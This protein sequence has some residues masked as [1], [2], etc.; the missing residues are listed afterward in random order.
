MKKLLLLV[1]LLTVS[2]GAGSQ[3]VRRTETIVA[4]LLARMPVYN[5]KELERQMEQMTLMESIGREIIL[6]SLTAPGMGD[7]TNARFAVESYSRYLSTPERSSQNSIW[8]LECIDFFNRTNIDEIKQFM[9]NQLIYSGGKPSALLAVENLEKGVLCESSAALLMS[10]GT[11]GIEKQVISLLDNDNLP[12]AAGVMNILAG[13]SSDRALDKLKK[14]YKNGTREEKRVALV[15][16]SKATDTEALSFLKNCA[17]K[18]GFISDYTGETDA[19]IAYAVNAGER[20]DTDV[21]AQVAVL[22]LKKGRTPVPAHYR[23]AALSMLAEF[24]GAEALNQIIQEFR[25]EDQRVSKSAIDFAGEIPG[26]SVTLK[27]CSLIKV[28]PADIATD[29]VAM[30]GHRGD[31]AASESL[32][33]ILFSS[34]FGVRIAGVGAIARLEGKESVETLIDYMRSFPSFEDQMAAMEALLFVADS[35][36]RKKIAEAIHDS[37]PVTKANLISLVAS[38]GESVYFPMV[39]GYCNSADNTIREI[40]YFSLPLVAR[41]GEMNLLISLALQNNNKKELEHLKIA[42]AQT[43]KYSEN[44]AAASRQFSESV[45]KSGYNINIL[46]VLPLIGDAAAVECLSNAFEAGDAESREFIYS[47]MKQ[48]PN[49]DIVHTLYELIASGNKSYQQRAFM[50]YCMR[51][52]KGNIPY[53]QKLLL[54]RRIEP[55]ATSPERKLALIGVAG[56]IRSFTNLMWLSGYIDDNDD[57]AKEAAKK[58]IAVALSGEEGGKGFGGDLAREIVKKAADL[59]PGSDEAAKAALWLSDMPQEEGFVSMFNGHNLD[60]WQGLVENPVA[61]S[62]MTARQLAEKQ[63]DANRAMSKNWS[64]DNGAIWFSGEGANLCSV[65]EYGDFEML[66]DWRITK[67]GDSGIYLRGTPQVQIWDTSRTEVGAQVGS[68]GLYNNQINESRPLVVADNPVT[69]WNSFR[70]VMKGELVS[71]WL[72]GIQVVDNVVM[73]NYW[74]RSQP[75]FRIGPIELQAHGN[76]LAFRDIYI[77]KIDRSNYGV[78]SEEKEEGFVSLFNGYDLDDWQGNKESYSAEKG[79]IVVKP[80][81]GSGGNLYTVKEYDNFIFRFDFQLTPGA[82]NGLGIRTPLTGDAAYVGMELQILDNTASVYANLEP[83]QYHGSVYGV[84]PAQRGFLKPVGEWNSQEVIVDGTRI[85]VILNGTVIVDGDITDAIKN[86]TMDH[87]E[88]PGLLREKGYI[89]FLGHGSMV[90]FR[91]IRIKEL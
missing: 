15:A 5:M 68:G 73:E 23:I 39:A 29:L 27:L 26:E 82:N 1:T 76:E 81:E 69:H 55:W 44:S 50:E 88:H 31:R 32:S 14:W 45:E 86:G 11:K 16:I 17:E 18:N 63:K 65:E 10:T 85:T 2:L 56:E 84:I 57:V 77:K 91:N 37:P 41:P 75:I 61:R 34:P 64:V 70:I 51:V 83:Y 36:A 49:I 54:I 28:M 22:L 79:V 48:W 87:N 3:D 38:G 47:L 74:A 24:K 43:V 89:G 62:R 4:D 58:A 59:I 90:R 20:G 30:L 42:I 66:V 33:Q 6:S 12:C 53:E 80:E 46:N 25:S 9:L 40:A 8:E 35:G 71:V 19:L 67:N 7:D 21:S 13:E 60:G 72:N 78:T 52:K